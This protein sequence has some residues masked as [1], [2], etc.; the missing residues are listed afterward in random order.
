MLLCIHLA[1]I[2]PPVLLSLYSSYTFFDMF[3]PLM[4]R[5]GTALHPDIFLSVV[6]TLGVILLFGYQVRDVILQYKLPY[7]QVKNR[8][9]MKNYVVEG[10]E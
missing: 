3:V 1:G 8:T 2:F 10:I 4:G 7:F 5:V 6:C 9:V